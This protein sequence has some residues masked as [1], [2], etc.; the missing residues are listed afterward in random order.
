M[1]LGRV[2]LTRAHSF[3]R[4]GCSRM[5]DAACAHGR[6][7]HRRLPRQRALHH[8]GLD[9]GT[10]LLHD[11]RHDVVA[12]D[13][14]R[15]YTA[16]GCRQG[17]HLTFRQGA[18]VEPHVLV[19][20]VADR[21]CAHAGIV[22]RAR[23]MAHEEH[24]VERIVEGPHRRRS[25]TGLPAHDVDLGIDLVEHE[26]AQHLD[27]VVLLH[28]ELRCTRG[29]RAGDRRVHVGRHPAP[30]PLVVLPARRDIGPPRDAADAFHVH[31]DEDPHAGDATRAWTSSARCGYLRS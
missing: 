16:L 21:V 20:A 23:V 28:D 6:D 3:D 19:R 8:R 5:D 24:R 7:D 12:R 4:A 25:A 2:D 11:P 22:T 30:R 15:R 14:S 18:T 13:E 1:R 9:A 29:T 31:R 27:A 10:D 26:V 17:E